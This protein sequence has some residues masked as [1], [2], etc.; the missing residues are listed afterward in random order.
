MLELDEEEVLGGITK[1]FAARRAA[2]LKMA[3][4][5]GFDDMLKERKQKNKAQ[6]QRDNA[7]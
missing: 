7:D 2:K 6:Q 3:E 5:G 1:V 4:S